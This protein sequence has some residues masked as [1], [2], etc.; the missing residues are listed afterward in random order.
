MPRPVP[1]HRLTF[2]RSPF[3][4]LLG[5]L[6]LALL[7]ATPALAQPP[8]KQ[9]PA[10]PA[11]GEAADPAAAGAPADP[12]APGAAA[13]QPAEGGAA[14]DQAPPAGEAPAEEAPAL[15]DAAEAIE[16]E[17]PKAK[18]AELPPGFNPPAV[19]DPIMGLKKPT[20]TDAEI[21]SEEAALRKMNSSRGLERA[22]TAG[23]FTDEVRAALPRWARLNL[24]KM[25]AVDFS[26]LSERKKVNDIARVM[27]L[28]LRNAATAQT[29]DAR[30]R[31]F[32]EALMAEVVKACQEV[33]DNNFYVRLQAASILSQLNS[34]ESPV[35]GQR[36]PPISYVP[37][38]APLLDILADPNQPAAVKVAAAAG[39]ARLA[40]DAES[41]PVDLRYRAADVLTKE[42]AVP[43]THPW[44]QMRVA[45]AL[46]AIEL[47]FNAARQPIVV[48]A[49]LAAINDD[50]RD[51]V[52]RSAAA[53]ALGR[54]PIPAGAWDDKAVA[55]ATVRLA[56][57]MSL[58]YNKAPSAV[59]WFPCF[60][61]LY[62]TFV[63]GQSKEQ[64]GKQEDLNRLPGSCLIRRGPS[65]PIASAQDLIRPIVSH[66]LKQPIDPRKQ[67]APIPGELIQPL[68]AFLKQP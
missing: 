40:D 39:V 21:K 36:Q 65:G 20:M 8:A 26:S 23:E 66:V 15:P 6:A 64:P 12:A 47:D 53:K 41:I 52:G 43:G 63:P 32:R 34:R 29:N 48:Q 31:E 18:G 27:M 45:E 25:A 22:V 11:A 61:S 38:M 54:T 2:G 7:A 62:L 55:T 51:C 9:P 4:R 19:A 5:L 50:K 28:T 37:A 46:A 24:A 42:L 59:H 57:D 58:A 3:R 13:E 67:H 35:A 33:L 68:D 56:R 1:P 49:L 14:P 60:E 44:Y 30:A 16:E 17:Q 10:A